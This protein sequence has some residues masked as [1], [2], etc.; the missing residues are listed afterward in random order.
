MPI[1][2]GQEVFRPRFRQGQIFDDR[3][4]QQRDEPEGGD[5]L[6]L[7][8]SGPMLPFRDDEFPRGNVLPTP[9]TP[10]RRAVGG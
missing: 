2:G 7:I 5:R 8:R 3:V 10:L 6:M 4:W 9:H 1:E